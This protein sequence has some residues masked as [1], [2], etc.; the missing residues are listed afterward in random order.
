MRYKKIKSHEMSEAALRTLWQE[1]YCQ[2]CIK[3]FDDIVVQFF[4]DM[5]D[6]C[7]FESANRKAKDKSILSLNRLEKILW[8]KDALADPDAV[9]KVGWDSK[10]KS[11]NDKRRVTLVKD[12]YIV[13]ILLFGE[14]KARFVTAYQVDDDENLKKIKNSPNYGT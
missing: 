8:I 12:N 7:F 11:H 14:R 5:F 10:T 1:E 6:H 2:Q 3:T 9:I 13:V 4:E